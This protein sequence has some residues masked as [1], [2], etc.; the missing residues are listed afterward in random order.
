LGD[1]YVQLQQRFDAAL[2]GRF[3]A[4]YTVERLDTVTRAEI[5]CRYHGLPVAAAHV[6]ALFEDET[7]RNTEAHGG[8]LARPINLRVAISW[9]A[10]ARAEVEEGDPWT[11]ALSTAAESTVIP[12]CC[13]RDSQGALDEPA[14]N[15]M[16][17]LLRPLTRAL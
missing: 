11:V 17:D 9:G 1:E 16:R 7:T 14:A 12:Y 2:L 4:Q 10:E 3:D 6:I 8:L 15:A 5:L 13:A